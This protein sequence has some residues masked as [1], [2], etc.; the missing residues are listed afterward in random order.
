VSPLRIGV[1]GLQGAAREHRAVL[2]RLGHH[3][4]DVR[5]PAHLA[6]VEALVIPGGESTTISMLLDSSGLREPI[7]ALLADGAPAF[8][9]CAGM[10]MLA[11]D[12]V[13]GRAD[14]ESFGTIDL[15]VRRNAFGRQLASFEAD[16]DVTGL[17]EPFR[18]V[19]IRAPYVEKVGEGVEVLATTLGPDGGPHAVVCRSGNVM[20]T[21][22]HPELTDD[23]RLHEL[24]LR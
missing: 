11:S 9:T 1:L 8:G 15:R 16:L 7:A 13:D 3:P 22:F 4:V 19:F 17:D 20:V 18:A 12:V 14:Q 2:E 5:R 24:W 10:I 21:A 23:T 6:G